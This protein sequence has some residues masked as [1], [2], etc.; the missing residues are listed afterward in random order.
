MTD[1]RNCRRDTDLF[2][3]QLCTKELGALLM[4]LPWLLDELEVT[5][6]RQDKLSTGVIGRSSDNPSPIN[7]GAMELARNLRGQLGTI[8]RDL[9][10]VRGVQPPAKAWSNSVMAEW[11]GT[12]L[13]SVVC[14]DTAGQIYREMRTGTDAVLAVINPISRMYC[15]PC[16]SVVAHSPN[17]E[18]IECGVDLYTDRESPQDIQCPKCKAWIN[19][20]EQLLVHFKR[21]DLMNEKE[22]IE[23]MTTVGE[24]VTEAVL[25]RW[26]RSNKLIVRGYMHQGR[27]IPEPVNNKDQRIF[28][29]NQARALRASENLESGRA[30]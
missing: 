7:V 8:I 2:L 24:P 27:I 19:P 26:Q 4:D 18:D 14:S 1:C 21:R 17:G 9:C 13:A 12:H 25:D 5:V 10:E 15:G 30:K 28:S 6:I 20:R 22:L 3:C 16:I 11:I 23:A 29:L